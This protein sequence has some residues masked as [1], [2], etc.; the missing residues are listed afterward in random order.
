MHRDSKPSNI[1]VK[2]QP[3]AAGQPVVV[4]LSDFGLARPF[5]LDQ[6]PEQPMTPK[7][8]TVYYRANAASAVGERVQ[9]VPRDSSNSWW[10]GDVHQMLVKQST[11]KWGEH[12]V[13]SS[14]HWWTAC[15]C[16][17]EGVQ[18]HLV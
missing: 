13:A 10:S 16:F 3:L 12:M 9:V 4:A 11:R 6:A 2:R 5:D 17:F 15:L 1:L 14:R 7:M 8:V 18:F